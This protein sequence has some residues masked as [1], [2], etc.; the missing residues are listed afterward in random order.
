MSDLSDKLRIAGLGLLA[1]KH[2][3]RSTGLRRWSDPDEKEM[4]ASLGCKTQKNEGSKRRTNPVRKQTSGN[5]S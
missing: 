2:L 5:H 1:E 3:S 4:G